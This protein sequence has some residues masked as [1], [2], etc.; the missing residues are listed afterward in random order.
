MAHWIWLTLMAPSPRSMLPH[1]QAHAAVEVFPVDLHERL[2]LDRRP[3]A[4]DLPLV[5]T[6][7]G[8]TVTFQ[9]AVVSDTQVTAQVAVSPVR[10]AGGT[11]LAA[12]VRLHRLL[13]VHV[14]GNT[15]GSLK[16]RPG[17]EVPE[18]WMKYLV[19]AAPFDTL[20]VLDESTELPLSAAQTAG[21]LLEV[22]IPLD[23]VRG[24][25]RGTLLVE[26]AGQ[27]VEAPFAFR[28]HRT[29]LPSP[30][31]L[32]SV[33]WL[34]PEPHNLT[35]GAVPEWWSERHWQL[36]EN[37]AKELRRFGDDTVYTPLLNYKDPLIQMTRKADGSLAFDY[38]RFDQWGELFLRL[39]FRYL[40]G[41]HILNLPQ[42]HLG[43]VFVLDERT[44]EKQPFPKDPKDREAWLTFLPTF[45]DSFAAHLHERGWTDHYLQHQYDEPKDSALYKRLTE[46]A[47]EHL[48]GVRTLD[49]IN[50][51]QQDVFSPLVDIQVFNLLGLSKF[52]GIAAKRRAE[53]KGVWLYHC[54]S[55]YPPHPNRHLDSHLTECRL[56]PWL[57]FKLGAD[58]F[59]HWGANIY[60][61][62]DEY[63]TSI[64][65]FPNRSQDP[66]HPPGDNWLYYRGPDGLR[67]SMR[68]V[69][70][71]EG[72]IDNALLT[73]LAEK[74]AAAAV[75][76]T[77]RLARSLTDY[78]RGSAAYHQSRQS[79]LELLDR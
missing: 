71:R 73:A 54:C 69:S 21:V 62:A 2:Y 43:G 49:A 60:R 10:R 24:E 33:H 50:S 14:E 23:A 58:G 15:Q 11:E 19:R 57:C 6:P 76:L 26:A 59:L 13:P 70:F 75:E 7:R 36:I 1:R 3:A 20:E 44:G 56:Y 22:E 66:G 28:V 39:G 48:P 8:S 35:N 9:F 55:P 67:P 17:G 46:M 12:Q 68:I 31:P 77:Q 74:D 16:N 30:L 38:T 5:A 34:W 53:G 51:A 45:Y 27:R 37:S 40:A 41:Q 4:A 79:L 78:E 61:G 52:Q 32:H 72:L 42:S 63:R 65:P 47:H 64:G 25:Y 18:G 29:A